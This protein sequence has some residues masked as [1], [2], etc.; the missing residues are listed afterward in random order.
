MTDMPFNRR[1]F[2]WVIWIFAG[3]SL[4]VILTSCMEMPAGPQTAT[5][6]LSSTPT[7]AL[8]QVSK[9]SSPVP[10]P[11]C[12][13]STGIDAG[14]LNIRTGAGLQYDV[15]RVLQEGEVLNMTGGQSGNWIQVITTRNDTGWINKKFCKGE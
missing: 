14:R 7:A 6:V 2:N 15:I 13:V 11:T 8:T 3:M 9:T 1:L 10:F 4:L 12:T 5:P